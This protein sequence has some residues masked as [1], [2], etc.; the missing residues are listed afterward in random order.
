MLRHPTMTNAGTA[1]RGLYVAA[2]LPLLSFYVVTLFWLSLVRCSPLLGHGACRW[3][4]VDGCCPA[5][6]HHSEGSEADGTESV[7][8]GEQISG[9]YVLCCGGQ[10][11]SIRPNLL[12]VALE[13]HCAMH[14]IEAPYSGCSH[15]LAL[16]LV[17]ASRIRS[18]GTDGTDISREPTKA[19]EEQ[20]WAHGAGPAV[21]RDVR[22]LFPSLACW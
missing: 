1:F 6:G 15:S 10:S 8:T 9:D 17:E 22:L 19:E 5:Q 20:L 3:V 16:C 13:E 7:D 12:V 18:E 4:V 14:T 11:V 21:C 2:R